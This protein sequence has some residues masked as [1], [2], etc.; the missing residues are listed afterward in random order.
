MSSGGDEF[1]HVTQQERDV[2]NRGT[3]EY[4]LR[5]RHRHMQRRQRHLDAAPGERG[6]FD[7]ISGPHNIEAVIYINRLLDERREARR[8]HQRDVNRMDRLP[9][10]LEMIAE[11][12]MDSRLAQSGRRRR[13]RR[14][15]IERDLVTSLAVI[16]SRTRSRSRV[17]RRPTIVYEEGIPVQVDPEYVPP[18][19]VFVPPE[20]LEIMQNVAADP[21]AYT[22]EQVDQTLAAAEYVLAQ[23]PR[24]VP[25]AV[26]AQ[27]N[28]LAAH[29]EEFTQ[30]EA[31]DIRRLAVQH[32]TGPQAEAL[33]HE[34]VEDNA[35]YRASYPIPDIEFE[36]YRHDRYDP[37]NEDP[38]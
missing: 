22:D 32:L 36:P 8:A 20:A 31:E 18:P 6:R 1:P 24:P 26:V 16:N 17:H 34:L 27:I 19:E 23:E 28:M 4:L 37:Y 38:Q 9:R 13:E 25:A 3:D 21:E 11:E 5:Q 2:L 35:N 15:Q 7:R 30:Q 12:N 14:R 10:R 33:L 29:P